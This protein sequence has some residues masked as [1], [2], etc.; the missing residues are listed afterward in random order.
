MY[1][2]NILSEFH[3]AQDGAATVMNNDLK[4]K[5]AIESIQ[6]HD[7]VQLV[8]IPELK[9]RRKYNRNIKCR[10]ICREKLRL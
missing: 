3:K 4:D 8:E 9:M 2:N 10:R 1:L 5:D 7:L 6:S